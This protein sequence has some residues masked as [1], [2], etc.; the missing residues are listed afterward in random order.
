MGRIVK[1]CTRNTS[2]ILAM[3]KPDLV[4]HQIEPVRSAQLWLVQ[5]DIEQ[6]ALD[7]NQPVNAEGRTGMPV[8]KAK[9]VAA[10]SSLP[11]RAI[12]ISAELADQLG[13]TIGETLRLTQD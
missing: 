10:N 12:A 9:I 4:V 1:R 13:I 5:S 8:I 11:L 3:P 7:P 6:L 2:V